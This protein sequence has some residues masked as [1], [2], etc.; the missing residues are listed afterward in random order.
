M[1]DVEEV[2]H[3]FIWLTIVE[4]IAK[5][6]SSADVFS[7]LFG[8]S[9]S[10]DDSSAEGSSRTHP[11]AGDLFLDEVVEPEECLPR[12]AEFAV[13]CFGFRPAF[14]YPFPC[15]FSLRFGGGHNR[16]LDVKFERP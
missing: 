12:L 15:R 16:S 14:P 10:C 3:S 6:R 9:Q 11:R 13:F 7:P 5:P 8:F 1:G 2:L 4:H